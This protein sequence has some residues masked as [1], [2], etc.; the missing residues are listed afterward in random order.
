[1]FRIASS[2]IFFGFTISFSLG[3]NDPYIREGS[4]GTVD[5]VQD[6]NMTLF[7][8]RWYM[9]SH[10]PMYVINNRD[11]VQT[12]FIEEDTGFF[13]EGTSIDS[14]FDLFQDLTRLSLIDPPT[15]ENDT[16]SADFV[17]TTMQ[18]DSKSTPYKIVALEYDAYACVYACQ[19]D[20]DEDGNPIKIEFPLTYLRDAQDVSDARFKCQLYFV[21]NLAGVVDWVQFRDVDHTDCEYGI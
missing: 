12:T 15:N 4:C 3:I 7:A 13:G 19:D 5:A 18:Q 8:G 1:M 14:S 2:W 10:Y 9:M 11:C 21:E 6:F 20:V 17:M 16:I